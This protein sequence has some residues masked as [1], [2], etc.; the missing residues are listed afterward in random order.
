MSYVNPLCLHHQHL[1]RS[2]VLA[3]APPLASLD[4]FISASRYPES[5]NTHATFSQQLQQK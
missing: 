1:P 3:D 5:Q 2:I 4:L